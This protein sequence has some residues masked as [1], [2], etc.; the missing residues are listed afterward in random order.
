MPSKDHIQQLQRLFAYFKRHGGRNTPSGISQIE[1][2]DDDDLT[3]WFVQ[4]LYNDENKAD[5]YVSLE[6]VFS[7]DGAGETPQDEFHPSK[8]LMQQANASPS[9][10]AAAAAAAVRIAASTPPPEASPITD[11]V[12]TGAAASSARAGSNGGHPQ[13]Q[14]EDLDQ[15]RHLS[16]HIA[17]QAAAATPPAA[18]PCIGSTAQV[19]VA[20]REEQARGTQQYSMLVD[21]EANS[22][23]ASTPVT[24]V[25]AATTNTTTATATATSVNAT[26]ARRNVRMPLVFIVAPRLIASFIHHG[27]LCSLELMS[28]RWEPTPENMT[29]LLIALHETLNPFSGDGR[30]SVDDAERVESRRAAVA[31]A[32]GLA[33]NRH[34]HDESGASAPGAYSAAEHQMG[35]DF[36]R[37]AHP[38]L[39]RRHMSSPPVGPAAQA[40][41]DGG[42]GTGNSPMA[43]SAARQTESTLS[44]SPSCM[45]DASAT[46][47]LGTQPVCAFLTST[48]AAVTSE[49]KVICGVARVNTAIYDALEYVYSVPAPL[50]S[51]DERHADP[52]L[53][54]AAHRQ[55]VRMILDSSALLADAG[56]AD[57]V[58]SAPAAGAV[59]EGEEGGV[60]GDDARPAA[61]TSAS[62]AETMP[63]ICAPA[64]NAERVLRARPPAASH[65]AYAPTQT[66]EHREGGRQRVVELWIPR[67]LPQLTATTAI[68]LPTGAAAPTEDASTHHH[69]TERDS[70]GDARGQTDERAHAAPRLC[71]L[72]VC[73]VGEH[74]PTR[75]SSATVGRCGDVAQAEIACVLRNMRVSVGPTRAAPSSTRAPHRKANSGNS[76]TSRATST[77]TGT[78]SVP[79]TTT[80]ATTA[81][82]RSSQGAAP[83][84][85]FSLQPSTAPSPHGDV[86]V[87]E[88][89]VGLSLRCEHLYLYGHVRVLGALTLHDC[90]FV[91]SIT[92]EEFASVQVTRSELALMPEDRLLRQAMPQ[93][94]PPTLAAPHAGLGR[95]ATERDPQ[96]S[97]AQASSDN[98]SEGDGASSG[99]GSS[100]TEGAPAEHPP[101]PPPPPPALFYAQRKECLLI[102]DSSSVEVADDSR[103]YRLMP[104]TQAAQPCRHRSRC[105]RHHHY[106]AESGHGPRMGSEGES[107]LEEGATEW[108]GPPADDAAAPPPPPPPAAMMTVLR[109][110]IL[111]SNQG[112]LRLVRCSVHPG[113]ST[114]RTILAEQDAVV[115]M[116]CCSVVAALSSAVIVQGC[117]AF[118]DRCTFVGNTAT[119]EADGRSE[120]HPRRPMHLSDVS[121]ST[122]LIVE[123]GGTLT[124]RFCTAQHVY[125]A[126]CVIA[127]SVAHLYRCH[128]DDVVNGYTIDASSATLDGCSANTNHVGVFVLRKAKC[129]I[130]DDNCGH[131]ARRCRLLGA[132]YDAARRTVL[133][134][135]R[136]QRQQQDPQAPGAELL[137]TS[138][139]AV[140]ARTTRVA[141]LARQYYADYVLYP[142]ALGSWIDG[143]AAQTAAAAATEATASL[144]NTRLSST[145]RVNKVACISS[146]AHPLPQHLGIYGGSFSLEVRDAA[147]KAVGVTLMNA[148]DTAVYA[149]DDSTVELEDCV[150]WT[151]AEVE[152]AAASAVEA[153]T[154]EGGVAASG[155]PDTSPPPPPPQQQQQ[156]CQQS[157]RENA[158][159]AVKA[160][161][162][163]ASTFQSSPRPSA[164]PRQ[165]SCGIKTVHSALTARRCLI[166]G[167]SFGVGAIQS[168]QAELTECVAAHCMNGFTVDHSTCRLKDCGAD[169]RHVG[170]F[171]LNSAVVEVESVPPVV[172]VV[173]FHRTPPLLICGGIPAVLCG[174]AYGVE[175][176]ASEM[177]CC[178]VTVRRGRD[179]GFNIYNKSQFTLLRSLVDM[180]PAGAQGGASREAKW[181]KTG[182]AE[183][184]GQSRRC[185]NAAS[186]HRHCKSNAKHHVDSN[187]TESRASEGNEA[188]S[189][190]AGA[191]DKR[192]STSTSPPPPSGNWL[193]SLTLDVDVAELDDP[194]STLPRRESGN[195]RSSSSS[196]SSDALTD[197]VATKD[198]RSP[199]SSVH[200]TTPTGELPWV[201]ATQ[202]SSTSAARSPTPPAAAALLTS[203]VKVW[204]GSRCYVRDS[205]VR[206]AT[207]GFAALGPETTLEAHHCTSKHVVN[208]FTADGGAMKLTMCSANSN[209][210]GIYVLSQ[211]RCL[212]RRGNYTAKRYGVEC[213]SGVVSF[214]GHVK[215][216]GFSRIGL[217]LYSGA[218]C[219]ADTDSVLDI[220]VRRQLAPPP[221]QPQQPGCVSPPVPT[222]REASEGST[223]QQH[224]HGCNASVVKRMLPQSASG[225]PASPL[226]QSP[227]PPTAVC[228]VDEAANVSDLL[229]ACIALDE[230]TAH[231]PQAILGGGACCG[232]TCA[233]GATGYIGM[234]IV[235]D[236]SL[237]G[238]NVA[239]GAHLTMANCQLQCARQY[240]VVVHVG[241]VC[242]MSRQS[243]EGE[244][245]DGGRD[246]I[247][248]G[249][250]GGAAGA[251]GSAAADEGRG[252]A[253][254]GA[255]AKEDSSSSGGRFRFAGSAFFSVWWRLWS[256]LRRTA[257][258]L[259]P[260]SLARWWAAHRQKAAL[261]Q[262]SSDCS[263]TQAKMH[264]AA[265]KPSL[266]ID[267]GTT[268]LSLL[269]AAMA[270][271]S[272]A[273]TRECSVFNMDDELPKPRAGEEELGERRRLPLM[274]ATRQHRCWMTPQRHR[275]A[276]PFQLNLLSNAS[277]V[278]S[279]A[280]VD[281]K[282]SPGVDSSGR[283]DTAG[284]PAHA[285]KSTRTLSLPLSSPVDAPPPPLHTA[286]LPVVQ[287]AIMGS[288]VVR[289]TC[290]IARMLL[291]PTFLLS[292]LHTQAQRQCK[293]ASA[294]E[295]ETEMEDGTAL[296]HCEG[297]AEAGG[298]ADDASSSG[299][300]E[301]I[302]SQ[303]PPAI[304]V[305]QHGVL[306]LADCLIDTSFATKPEANHDPK[307]ALC[308]KREGMA[309][310]STAPTVVVC[311]GPYARLHCDYV[312]VLRANLSA[313]NHT[314]DSSSGG[315]L[316]SSP[317]ASS[318]SPTAERV[319]QPA[320]DSLVVAPP[321]FLSLRNGAQ[322]TLHMVGTSP[323]KWP[324]RASTSTAH[325]AAA[326]AAS[327]SSSTN[328]LGADVLGKDKA[329][330]PA[331][332][333][334]APLPGAEG[335]RGA[336]GAEQPPPPTPDPRPAPRAAL[337]EHNGITLS[338]SK[339]SLAEA[340]LAAFTR[341]TVST[342]SIL[343][344][345]DCSIEGDCPFPLLLR[346]SSRAMLMFCRVVNTQCT[347][348]RGAPAAAAL[349][350]DATSHATLFRS[351]VRMPAS[352]GEPVK[353]VDGGRVRQL[354]SAV[355]SL[356]HAA[357]RDPATDSRAGSEQE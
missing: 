231:V 319:G 328:L 91:G 149:V 159:D 265:R 13:R 167:F 276:L 43:P 246:M 233:D 166:T 80:A 254:S 108:G 179:S 57:R 229:P 314:E 24:A 28:Q 289:G 136:E 170:I 180:S 259:M 62:T 132:A 241:G 151:T 87:C 81:G 297:K 188:P 107:E 66:K 35:I 32:G 204:S 97:Q 177:R 189:S 63:A 309:S 344:L 18:S 72:D 85:R 296:A 240:A 185:S 147:L 335:G 248:G 100:D 303:A 352:H 54:G 15:Q 209:H 247:A 325:A 263:S 139:A 311:D 278:T 197:A 150:L 96:S 116:A 339:D 287:P 304:H 106:R 302:S 174:D 128:T 41:A 190:A 198:S 143:T 260:S 30:V 324:Y 214:Q 345:V 61:T 99:L 176:K 77:G 168:S 295:E 130:T 70:S 351:E 79:T 205:E 293:S 357:P 112:R 118:L 74:G 219:E 292:S 249:G 290:T 115:D 182:A 258:T 104:E 95:S 270:A 161:H 131:F 135:L 23:P 294:E 2:V 90:I 160:A 20:V 73:L 37:R 27:A 31:A 102:L 346:R 129:V 47:T 145:L 29:L 34:P 60:G 306:T 42:G 315:V 101:P 301:Q 25:A 121:R 227:P 341:V 281:A 84:F 226:Q 285:G 181:E 340:S 64:M 78:V 284:S 291:Q 21:S 110:L 354:Q 71:T 163:A 14:E 56:R 113:S 193:C 312:C 67:S 239:A 316:P 272:A 55:Q 317:M 264:G 138:A 125:F 164:G 322:C 224:R 144:P 49:P 277:S 217:Y 6:L 343:R 300:L 288:I 255:D 273:A 50:D 187:H 142:E 256:S 7:E 279:A 234:C 92:A 251:G 243:E 194:V 267:G 330:R 222:A 332:S 148:R 109:S 126:F 45:P 157:V 210:V 44:A 213:R 268:T 133:N 349:N 1:L 68:P 266:Y 114:E 305:F 321:P 4:L 127:H 211:G 207:F 218:H 299:S 86:H 152:D 26:A 326:A 253:V 337:P 275:V 203:G 173:S 195:D 338:L 76:A 334:E 9:K 172:G 154:A 274:R 122:G 120:G 347:D 192:A 208:G 230:A 12:Q 336:R 221:Q 199:D 327:S 124:A 3:H 223:H 307:P 353:C 257:S 105:R 59:G 36:I 220:H 269:N 65:L 298:A 141:A 8:S 162:T 5:F 200:A 356:D 11:G 75:S 331:P 178:G 262:S 237:V 310:S 83:S 69:R 216:H 134:T 201:P 308:V 46:G 58:R 236:C 53:Q 228:G 342:R 313:D 48:P 333:E 165:S 225:S 153:T 171:A 19:D 244:S 320:H 137:G 175:C 280:A 252:V 348:P 235:H 261:Y 22:G 323:D 16:L 196:S 318:T 17:E 10:V 250:L 355:T 38:H 283:G 212:V 51:V 183:T 40:S 184:A 329:D 156:G 103:L 215:I 98:R 350:V 94:F 271:Y 238:V 282:R 206:C 39:F 202:T 155:D 111:V 88:I 146:G 52:Q 93:A 140:A 245:S 119:A 232:I 191:T 123:L 242:L 82:A 89:P 117:R 33:R 158:I 186:P 169:T 286:A